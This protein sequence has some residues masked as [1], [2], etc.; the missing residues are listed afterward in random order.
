MEIDVF[1]TDNSN[2]CSTKA[3]KTNSSININKNLE[4]AVFPNVLSL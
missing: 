1:D 2:K 3:N 4:L